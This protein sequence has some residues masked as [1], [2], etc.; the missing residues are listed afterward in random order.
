[1]AA[2][3]KPLEQELATYERER[4]HLEREHM[5]KFV[6]IREDKVIGTYDTFE[7]AAKEGVSRFKNSPFLIRQVGREGV[8]L[9]PAIVYGFTRAYIRDQLQGPE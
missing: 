6:L 8:T 9:S 3:R 7:T 2:E 1:M 5:G 4:A